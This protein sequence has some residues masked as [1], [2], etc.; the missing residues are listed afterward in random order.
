MRRLGIVLK[1]GG[2]EGQLANLGTS[3]SN[4]EASTPSSTPIKETEADDS[5][6]I[7]NVVPTST[8]MELSDAP[9]LDVSLTDNADALPDIRDGGG[10]ETRASTRLPRNIG[11]RRSNHSKGPATQN[12]NAVNP[13]TPSP[14]LICR[15]RRESWGWDIT[16]V[17]PQESNIAEVRQNE[18]SLSVEEGE[19][20]LSGYSGHLSVRFEDGTTNEIS[21]FG[22]QPLIFKS[23]K[24]WTGI[25]RRMSGITQGYFVVFVPSQ[26]SRIGNAPVVAAACSDTGFLAHFFIRHRD[27]QKSGVT[28]FQEYPLLPT[29]AALRLCGER[30]FDNSEQG[31]LF[32]GSVP[33]LKHASG[34]VWARVGEE[35]QNGWKGEIFK[36]TE[37]SLADVLNGRQGRLFV[38]VFDGEAKL[39]DSDEFRYLRDLR[40][41]RMNGQPYSA[42]TI[43]VPPSTGHSPTELQFVGADGATIQPAVATDGNHTTVQAEGVVIVAPQPKGDEV[44]CRLSS[45]KSHIDTVINLPRIWWRI[46]RDHGESDDWRDTPWSMTRQEFRKYANAGTT[47]RLG[48]PSQITSVSVGFDEELGRVYR[49]PQSGDETEL[50]LADFVD[51]SQIDQRLNT[52]ASL[53]V[54]C[55][56]AVMTVVRISADPV[57]RITSFSSEPATVSAGEKA[58]LQWVTRNA[59]SCEVAIDP[60]IGS[61]SLSG[62]MPIVPT[63]TTTFTLRLTASGMDDVTTNITVTV[64][65]RLGEKLFAC[66]KRKDGGLRRG[67]GF[68]RGE[69]HASGLT[70]SDAVRRSLPLDRR[71]RSTHRT[72]VDTIREVDIDA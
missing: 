71:R 37:R 25:G 56:E 53:N 21:L 14:K 67:T 32:V 26:W 15:K 50:C 33:T 11:G 8:S 42:N 19:C 41:I 49:S 22:D 17:V 61:V 39:L 12:E 55:G 1:H 20:Q 62:N 47:I 27:D 30:A 59:E 24:D 69:I 44:S 64:R 51:Y 7:T 65:Y 70:H 72:N 57:P 16:L 18:T 52:D 36:P 35:N 48:L 40:E 58:L 9:E 54:Q 5:G 60:D 38:R 45:G 28:G 34:V 46:E 66:V 31:E 23:S 68:S 13:I 2:G 3:D 6:E 63:E 29:Q 43:L 4:A 10:V